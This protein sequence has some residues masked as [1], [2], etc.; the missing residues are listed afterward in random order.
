MLNIHIESRLLEQTGKADNHFELSLPRPQ[1]NLAHESLKDP[2]GQDVLGLGK[3]AGARD[4]ENA[5]VK[6]VPEFLL[7]QAAGFAFVG[8]KVMLAW[9]ATRF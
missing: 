3:E 5:L 4:N 8:R 6:Q 2:Y 7:G 1:S 9:A